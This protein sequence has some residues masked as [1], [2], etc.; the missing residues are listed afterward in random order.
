MISVVKAATIGLICFLLGRGN[1]IRFSRALLNRVLGE[2][3][4]R[5][6]IG[7]NGE[8]YVAEKVLDSVAG[9]RRNF[10]AFDAGA[11]VGDWVVMYMEL[12]AKKGISKRIS[13]HCFEPSQYTFSLL[14][15]TIHGR[16]W[17]QSVVP[18]NVGMGAREEDLLLYVNEPGAGTSS[19]YKRRLE[20]VGWLNDKFETVN[21]T[22]VDNYCE[23]ASIE[24]ILFLKV[25]TEGHELEVLRGASGMLERKAID[26]IQ[27]EYGGAWIDSRALMMDM[28]DFITEYG[29]SVGKIYPNGVEFY[30]RYDQR[31]ETF[32]LANFLVTLPEH[33]E[34]FD[35]I[36]PWM[37]R[38]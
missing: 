13:V 14:E 16:S 31:L 9:E 24:N 5:L 33:M 20:S 17:E 7:R 2:N 1:T 21:V 23:R 38:K 8:D 37:A 25:D 15:K 27:F 6:D 30:D 4:D 34:I 11:N 12:A 28:W 32:Q 18:V 3:Q 10:I 22:T 29:Y 19:L 35:R 26:F 36:E